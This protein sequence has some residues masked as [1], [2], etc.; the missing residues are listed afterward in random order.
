MVRIDRESRKGSNLVCVAS[1]SESNVGGWVGWGGAVGASDVGKMGHG[2]H[3][4]ESM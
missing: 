2:D 4:M 3:V 1:A